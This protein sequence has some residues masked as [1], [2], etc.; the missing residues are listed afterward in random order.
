[1]DGTCLAGQFLKT[2][3]REMQ[4]SD[5]QLDRIYEDYGELTGRRSV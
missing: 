4:Y 3:V 5:E 1:M 2:Q